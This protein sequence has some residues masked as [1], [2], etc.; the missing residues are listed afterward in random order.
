MY[1]DPAAAQ[2]AFHP[3]AQDWR[4]KIIADLLLLGVVSYT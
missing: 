2:V 4:A 1:L 3:E